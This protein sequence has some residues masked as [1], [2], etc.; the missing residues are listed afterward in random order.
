M[1]AC[2]DCSYFFEMH[3]FRCKS[4][5]HTAHEEN[6]LGAFYSEYA[7]AVIITTRCKL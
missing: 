2:P 7:D 4:N 6:M 1:H 3:A 5:I